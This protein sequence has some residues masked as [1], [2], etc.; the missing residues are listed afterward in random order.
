MPQVSRL[1]VERAYHEEVKTRTAELLALLCLYIV[2]VHFDGGALVFVIRF[3][4]DSAE[5]YKVLLSDADVLDFVVLL[6][7]YV[8]LCYVLC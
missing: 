8:M 3:V 6:V 2:C 4:L 7:L 1:L 5:L